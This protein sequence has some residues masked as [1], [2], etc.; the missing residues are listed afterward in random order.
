MDSLKSVNGNNFLQAIKNK[1]SGFQEFW[2]QVV[3]HKY[4]FL[5]FLALFIAGAYLINR[6]TTPV[7]IVKSSMLVKDPGAGGNGVGNLL[8][9]KEG[10]V[11]LP[12]GADKS[13]EVA[14][15]SSFPFIYKTVKALDFAV[16]YFREGKIS[17]HEIYGILPFQVKLPDTS[18]IEKISG[19]RFNISFTD[20]QNFVLEDISNNKEGK[21]QNFQVGQTIQI[22][23][24]PII[25]NATPHFNVKNDLKQNFEFKIND[26]EDLALRFREDLNLTFDDEESSILL[27]E[28]STT[29]PK[30]GIDF[31]NEYTKQYIK[32]KYE[33]KSRAA[34]QALAFINEQLNTVK[35]SL[36]STESNLANFKAS[37]T[38]TDASAMANRSLD[39][40]TQIE[41]EKANLAI[42]D[43][44][45]STILGSLN[46]N[47]DLDQLVAPS[48]VGIQ[49]GT[50]DNLIKQLSD[51]QIEKN[52]YAA[53]G[54]SKN[55]L[56]QD[57]DIKINSV[58][59]TLKQNVQG[60]ATT[61]RLRMGQLNARAGQYQAKIFSVP[62]AEKTFTDIKRVSDFNDGLYQFLMQKRVEAGIL[63]AS[64]TVENKI[65][66]PPYKSS[67]P[68]EPKQGRNYVFAVLLGLLIPFGIMRI[69]T[70]LNKRLTGK[71][72]IQSSTTIPIIGS[73]YRNQDSN[74][75][76]ISSG[77][78][79]AVSESFRILRS[80]IAHLTK[81]HSKKLLLITST[82][83]GEGKSFTSINIASSFALAKKKTILV[84]L[85]LRV[86][87]SA[88]ETLGDY[89]SGV[90]SFLEGKASVTDIIQTTDVSSLH[91]I[92][93]GELPVNPAE[94]L[95]EGKLETLFNYLRSNYDYIIVDTPPLGI[96][97]DPLII[98]N[99]SDLNILVVREK[100][101]LKESL[102]ELEQMYM[103]GK[104]KD[105]VMVINDVRLD[106]KG[107]SNAYYY[108]N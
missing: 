88:Y 5:V 47:N 13:E 94:L 73:I 57:L 64:A 51:L 85:D 7:Y 75:I 43:R 77:E 50:T 92:A 89:R 21:A 26:L 46:S 80:N 104:I 27:V 39:A 82:N 72:E 74:P 32:D 40:L 28:L 96:V 103:E 41:N 66:E 36:G 9:A 81:T 29:V 11:E 14:M 34:S 101:T 106:K 79:T 6:Y 42:T 10:S 2:K 52:S 4:L 87:S 38:F 16:S 97:A 33:E 58:K 69:R 107:Y 15:L 48:S 30:K 17:I 65:I 62:L 56:A 93:T 25:I 59:N 20:K 1:K 98:S 100:Y 63:K 91:Y 3:A 108:K 18:A 37:N 49:D 31:L 19:K 61:N 67:V 44:Y 71:E 60:L 105:V 90:S 68:L 76:V 22:N 53:S 84:N 55:P 83:S 54:N 12:A 8:L 23:G 95:M 70:S 78:R 102:Y 45:Y 99:Y 86:P 24:C 35:G